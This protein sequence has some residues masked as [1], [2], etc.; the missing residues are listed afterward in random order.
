MTMRSNQLFLVLDFL[1]NYLQVLAI[2]DGLHDVYALGKEAAAVHSSLM[3]NLS[4][5]C[6]CFSLFIIFPS[7]ISIYLLVFHVHDVWY[8]LDI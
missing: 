6:H 5:A 8:C 2:A 1:A 3:T 7:P 4:K